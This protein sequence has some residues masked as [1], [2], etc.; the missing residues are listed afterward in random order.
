[1]FAFYYDRG[2]CIII[3]RRHEASIQPIIT[4]ELFLSYSASSNVNSYFNMRQ[5]IAIQQS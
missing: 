4:A 2:I 1:M 3:W 5:D